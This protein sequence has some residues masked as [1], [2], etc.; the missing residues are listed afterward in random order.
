MVVRLDEKQRENLNDIRNLLIPTPKGTQIP[1]YQVAEVDIITGPAQIQREDA[2]RRIV[3]GFNIRGRDVQSI[4]NELSK[5]AE[6]QLQFSPG[7]Y[8]TYGGAFENLNQAKDRLMI[9]VP[10]SLALIFFH[11][12]TISLQSHG[13]DFQ[14]FSFRK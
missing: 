9:A 6:Q 13:F 10:E 11:I 4:V 14:F 1:L 12:Y 7:Y 5:K 2:K 8:I 3:I